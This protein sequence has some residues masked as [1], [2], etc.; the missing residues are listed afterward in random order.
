MK[1]AISF[2]SVEPNAALITPM[3]LAALLGVGLLLWIVSSRFGPS[4]CS[5][6]RPSR[7]SKGSAS[8]DKSKEEGA[9]GG[10]AGVDDKARKQD[11]ST[12]KKSKGNTS[13]NKS[14]PR[15]NSGFCCFRKK[16]EQEKLTT[17]AVGGAEVHLTDIYPDVSKASNIV[18]AKKKAETKKAE[19]EEEEE[20]ESEE[21]EV[22]DEEE[23]EE[24]EATH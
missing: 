2:T 8:K 6:S 15:C 22:S 23:E 20:E 5:C 10:N 4:S 1:A 14:T 19:E 13:H 24:V 9:T 11:A 16:Q 12:D 17:R 3:V 18:V 7:G 21:E